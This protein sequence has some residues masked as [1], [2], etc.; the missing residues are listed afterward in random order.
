MKALPE[1]GQ[2][3]INGGQFLFG[4]LR[5]VFLGKGNDLGAHNELHQLHVGVF[6]ARKTAGNKIALVIFAH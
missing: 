3:P 2:Q 5:L 1:Q 4:L 6:A